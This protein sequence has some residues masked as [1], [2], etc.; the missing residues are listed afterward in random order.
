VYS[1]NSQKLCC[2]IFFD[3]RCSIVSFR[4]TSMYIL[5]QLY[6]YN[7]CNI[8]I[9]PV[10]RVLRTK[11]CPWSSQHVQWAVELMACVQSNSSVKASGCVCVRDIRSNYRTTHCTHIAREY[12]QTGDVNDSQGLHYFLHVLFTRVVWQSNFIKVYVRLDVEHERRFFND[13]K[14]R[15]QK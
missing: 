10:G 11:V 6:V 4:R 2:I 1:W 9:T 7:L 12:G 8:V 14:Y 3:Q 13:T 5:L 15:F